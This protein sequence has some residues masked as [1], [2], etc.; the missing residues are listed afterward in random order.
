MATC[1][2]WDVTLTV[3]HVSGASFSATADALR[4]WHLGQSYK[5]KVEALL[6]D[7]DISCITV[8]DELFHLWNDL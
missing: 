3:G 6:I 1:I 4:F 7:N 2:A 5:N 8:P